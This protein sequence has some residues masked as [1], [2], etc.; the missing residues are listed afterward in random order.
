MKAHDEGMGISNYSKLIAAL[1][2]ILPAMG[3][4]LYFKANSRGNAA[5]QECLFG[6]IYELL[7]S[8]KVGDNVYE[9]Y[10]HVSGWPDR[11]ESISLFSPP[12]SFDACGQ[13]LQKALASSPV[14][15]GQEGKIVKWPIRFVVEG[16][17]VKIR[18]SSDKDGR[19]AMEDV[20]VD[21]KLSSTTQLPPQLTH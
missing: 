16:G 17:A 10:L 7:E 12:A 3:L 4:A 14:E 18:Y 15:Y 6:N 1:A 20:P 21:W 2:I 5:S 8:Q 13:P 11:I 19:L 9:L